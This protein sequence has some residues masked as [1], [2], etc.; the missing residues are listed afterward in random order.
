MKQLSFALLYLIG[1]V[2]FL[3]QELQTDPTMDYLIT[4]QRV[5]AKHPLNTDEQ[6]KRLCAELQHT[7]SEM[8]AL[9]TL[10][11]FGGEEAS[12]NCDKML[13]DTFSSPYE[14]ADFVWLRKNIEPRVRIALD[15]LG[16]KLPAEPIIGTI[17]ATLLNAKAI[18]VPGG[19]RPLIVLNDEVFRLPYEITRASVQALGFDKA[20]NGLTM[21]SVDPKEI[22][23]RING[24]PEL[25]KS[26]EWAM[27]R[28]L[29]LVSGP[30]NDG[31]PSVESD[32]EFVRN[33]LI[34]EGLTEAMETFIL[35][36][37]FAHLILHHEVDANSALGLSPSGVELA[38][39]NEASYSWRQEFEA[40]AYGFL[41]FEE[42]LKQEAGH[43]SGTY[44]K[45]PLYPFYL[46][47]PR[48]FFSIMMLVDDANAYV[49]TGKAAL[50]VSKEDI[51]IA[52]KA[53][54]GL[55]SGPNQGANKGKRSHSTATI[56]HPPFLF[57]AK[58]AEILEQQVLS[59]FFE[60]A[61]LQ[62]ETR[63]FYRL[64]AAIGTATTVLFESSVSEFRKQ[65]GD[66]NK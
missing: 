31:Y 15:A 2:S 55:S 22:A 18:R 17:P 29:H 43:R 34:L 58:Q 11:R 32:L 7:L 20:S 52:K 39:M 24:Q 40:D 12:F 14:S 5:M 65:N 10:K 62:P 44:L 16:K 42:V 64:S 4:L 3:G 28:Y 46:Y 25:Q 27:L 26:F 47:A 63:S 45:D 41:I 23:A 33:I 8:K 19:R 6:Q 50:P 56:S 30:P 53:I 1:S 54:S 49:R 9:N 61:D 57:R 51:Q 48:F 21:T 59:L 36:H 13:A 37:E 66:H 35:S 60:K 38:K